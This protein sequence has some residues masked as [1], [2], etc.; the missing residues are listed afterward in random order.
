ML[1]NRKSPALASRS[2]ASGYDIRLS[3]RKLGKLDNPVGPKF[4]KDFIFDATQK[5]EI[6]ESRVVR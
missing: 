6:I 1:T 2:L 4:L 5:E 3:V